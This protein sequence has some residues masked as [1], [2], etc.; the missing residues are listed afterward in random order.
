MR[1]TERPEEP[2]R[3]DEPSLDPTG[4]RTEEAEPR[5]EEG[6]SSTPQPMPRRS[7]AFLVEFVRLVIVALFAVGGWEV[8]T[9]LPEVTS[10]KLLVSIALGSM[11][12]FVIG[13]VFGRQTAS[14]VSEVE[15]EFRRIPAHVILAGF[16]GTIL[17]LVPAALLSIPLFHLPAVAA[18]S[19]VALLYVVLGYLG[20]RIGRTRSEEMFGVFGVKP[21]AAGTRPGEVAVLDTSAILD[22]RI[23][24][25]ARMHFLTG[26]LLVTRSVLSE[27]QT[28]ADSSDPARRGRGRRGLDTLVALRHEPSSEV[29]LVEQDEPV[30][31][32]D[33]DASLVRLARDRGGVLVT[34]D[35]NLA[36]VAAAL[37]VP[38]RSIHALAAA[39]RPRVVAGDGVDVLI[40]R[41]GRD[42]GQG[43]GYLDDGTMVVVHGGEAHMGATVGVTVTNVLQTANGQMVF[44]AL[45]GDGDDALAAPPEAGLGRISR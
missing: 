42:A 43:V 39:L 29:I 2:S 19:T 28:I 23:L 20:Y 33:V 1:Q 36:K 12:G 25:L 44:A 22:D 27:L 40:T 26:S 17:G 30:A 35:A 32:G 15:R 16:I 8:G 5:A 3:P 34:N 6:P 21:R 10:T 4:L 31:Q 41:K 18:F 37:D 38:V 9:N 7:R 45:A 13:G 24:A 11:I 14:A